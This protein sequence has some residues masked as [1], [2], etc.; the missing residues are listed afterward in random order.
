MNVKKSSE[1]LVYLQREGLWQKQKEEW[2]LQG[3][4]SKKRGRRALEKIHML[5]LELNWKKQMA[6]KYDDKSLKNQ[7]HIIQLSDPFHRVRGASREELIGRFETLKD[8]VATHQ[9]KKL[10]KCQI[11]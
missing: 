5:S 7:R 3:M 6:S 2:S 10:P 4:T 9:R 1:S 11:H 8:S